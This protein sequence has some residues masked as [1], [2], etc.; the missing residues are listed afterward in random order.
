MKIK[1]LG[2]ALFE[3]QRD[4]PTT[5]S[6]RP[7]APPAKPVK[8][9]RPT[10][11]VPTTLLPLADLHKPADLLPRTARGTLD[12]DAALR[13]FGLKDVAVLW[14]QKYPSGSAGA[15]LKR[16]VGAIGRKPARRA[17]RVRLGLEG[18]SPGASPDTE[19][20]PAPLRPPKPETNLPQPATKVSAAQDSSALPLPRDASGRIDIAAS[21]ELLGLPDPKTLWNGKVQPGSPAHELKKEIARVLA[22]GETVTGITRQDIGLPD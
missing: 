20:P 15:A 6:G 7:K 10:V 1:I 16:V 17:I 5:F 8:S 12:A 9:R 4:L 11:M 21:L 22:R 2:L 19:R 14:Q 13:L 3:I 18:L